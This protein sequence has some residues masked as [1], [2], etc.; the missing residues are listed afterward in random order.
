MIV[1]ATLTGPFPRL[2]VIAVALLAAAAILSREEAPR[3]WAMLG[4]LALAPVLLLADI[5]HS[6]QLG[7]VHRHPLPVVIGAALVLAALAALARVIAKRP[8]LVGPLAAI[9]LPFRIPIS[10]TGASTSKLLVP[11]YFVIAAAA[12]AWLVPVLAGN[13]DRRDEGRVR[14]ASPAVRGF[15]QLLAGYVVLYAVQATYSSDFEQ[16][17]QNVVFFYVPFAL[18]F[19]LV[20]DLG[21]DRRLILRTLV[22][23]A[24]L[25]VVFACIAFVEEATKSVFLN[26]KLIETN[27][28]HPWFTVNSVF[29]DPDIFG[30]YLAIVMVLLVAVLLYERRQNVQFGVSAVLAVLWGGLVLTLSRSSLAALLL[31][32]ATLAAL[33]WRARPVVIA[34]AVVLVAG[35]AALAISPKTFGLN[36]G[37]NNASSGRA[38]LVTGGVSMFAARPVWGYG[39]GRS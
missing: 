7:F 27:S 23:T 9:A 39:S 6:P 24:A 19:G 21:W 8:W 14:R 5:W 30:R 11:L 28:S 1:F 17:L 33:R 26:T 3:A 35:G 38:N 29:Y 2:G 16:A 4:A 25:A 20:R 18:L 34:A 22:P 36:Q 32:M 13:R 12:L 10:T 15:E 31:G 37:L